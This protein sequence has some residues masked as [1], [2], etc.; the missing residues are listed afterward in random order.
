MR[1]MVKL[2]KSTEKVQGT[3][4]IDPDEVEQRLAEVFAFFNHNFQVLMDYLPSEVC[5]SIISDVWQ[6]IVEQMAFLVVGDINEQGDGMINMTNGSKAMWNQRRVEFMKIASQVTSSAK[7]NCFSFW[8]YSF[9]PM[10]MVFRKQ[11]WKQG[12][13]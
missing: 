1:K 13:T 3:L 8:P 4:L 9:K 5:M 7:F 11:V 6:R 10:V 2:K 12:L